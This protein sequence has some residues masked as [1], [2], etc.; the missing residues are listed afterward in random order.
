M[1]RYVSSHFHQ[2][3]NLPKCRHIV[4]SDE[5]TSAILTERILNGFLT[6]PDDFINSLAYR[7]LDT[8]S[9]SLLFMMYPSPSET[10]DGLPRLRRDVELTSPV[11]Q[12]L[13]PLISMEDSPVNLAEEE[14]NNINIKVKQSQRKRKIAKRGGR[15]PNIDSKPF[16][17]MELPIPMSSAEAKKL[18]TDLILQQKQTLGV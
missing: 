15:R 3:T 7:L 13:T 18:A 4:A 1:V 16:D 9:L 11:L 5:E 8:L 17:D 10:P 2:L 12:A 14:T 6:S